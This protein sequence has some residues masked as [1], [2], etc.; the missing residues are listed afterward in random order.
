MVM[1]DNEFETKEIKDMYLV[2]KKTNY[3]E[4]N[5]SQILNKTITDIVLIA[6]R[7]HKRTPWSRCLQ[8]S[9]KLTEL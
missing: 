9:V 1:Y 2:V 8:L 4:K 5:V 6:S 7:D 3:M